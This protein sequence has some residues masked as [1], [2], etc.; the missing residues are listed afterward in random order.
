MVSKRKFFSITIMMFILL[1]LF[2][3][4]M[5]MRDRQNAYD[6][7]SELTAKKADGQNAWKQEET[8]LK[9]LVE[10]QESYVLFIGDAEKNMGIAVERWCTYTKRS[11][12]TDTSLA[13]YISKTDQVPEIVILESEKYADA[14]NLKQ[15]KE[16]VSAGSIVIFGSLEDAGEI[17]KNSELMN[18]LGIQKVV[19]K[20]VKLS[21]I[22]LFEGLLLGGEVVYQP[23][24]E[25]EKKERQDLNFTV[26]WYQI[27]S[28]TKAYMVGLLDEKKMK[29]EKLENEDLPTLIW[30][31]GIENGSIFAVC[32]DYLKD[33]T[34]IGIL[35]G[36]VNEASEYTVYPIVNAQNLSMVNFPGFAEENNEKLTRLYSRSVIGINRDIMWPALVSTAEQSKLRMTCFIQPQSDYTD[37][38]EPDSK[39]L[40]FYLKQLKEQNAEAGLSLHY[41]KASSMSDKITD[42]GKFFASADSSYVYGA[43][44]VNTDQLPLVLNMQGTSLLKTVGTLVC[45][46]TEE[47]PLLSYCDDAVTLQ[48]VT[49]DGMHY[50]YGDD[51]RMRSIQTALGYT[52][53]MLN[54]QDIYWPEDSDDGWQV[55]QEKFASNLLTY[56]KKFSYFTATTLSESNARTRS[57]LKL[58]YSYS[59]DDNEAILKTTEKNSW[60]LL[61]THGKEIEETV[62]G[63]WQKLEENVYMIYAEQNTVRVQFKQSRL[64]YYTQS[65]N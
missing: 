55:M 24:T 61:R 12:L 1:F 51:L 7:N 26:P 54:M 2:Q 52:N 41:R 47:Y 40:V 42:D 10:N 38:I 15:L 21:G 29:K 25:K 20:N 31:N 6:V 22:K 28:G 23:D 37:D 58:D 63:S 39:N 3:F 16:Y 45:D 64:H 34:A 62:G 13:Q 60:F 57:F 5:I 65:G 33:S 27:E 48:E 11:L 19:S 36:M 14:A 44:F 8:D 18:F 9:T 49:N 17:Q 53:V 59:G 30:R 50:T 46:Y 56:W 4:S 35:D 43:A 32:G